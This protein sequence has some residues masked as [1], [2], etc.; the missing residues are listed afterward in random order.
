QRGGR[1][2]FGPTGQIGDSSVQDPTATLDALARNTGG[3]LLARTGDVEAGMA[4]IAEEQNSYYVLGYVP[5]KDPDPG[6]CHSLKVKVGRD[7]MNVRA[8]SEY[9]EAK[10]L[11]VLA[12]T[13]TQ[14]DLEARLAGNASSTIDASVQAPFFY[15]GENTAR[16]DLALDV[17]G[18]AVRFVKEKGKFA[19]NL[20]IVGIAFLGDGGVGARFSDNIRL[21][22][23]SKKQVEEFA[24]QPYHYEKQFPIG[25]GDYRLKIAFTA[26]ESFGK[27]EL[28]LSVQPWTPNRFWLSGL[29]L[30]T[31][32]HPASGDTLS[33]GPGLFDDKVPL[34]VNGVQLIPAGTNRLHKA[35]KAY[36]YAE[37]YDPDLSPAEV[38][39][40]VLDVQSGKVVKDLG[41]MQVNPSSATELK[42][43]PLGI[44]LPLS[45][46]APGRY[47]VK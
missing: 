32:A 44:A 24:S 3:F 40:E 22:F 30:S 31:S 23:D 19:G 16:I 6:A 45:D 43:I 35:E 2:G 15:T 9:C 39:G 28:P 8:R 25:A 13:P 4:R 12:G 7:G 36:L 26:G 27:V 38:R 20:N 47:T 21:S 41:S 11:D 37:V 17:S 14:R 46:L 10:P 33:L 42:A 1:G 5:T 18:N 29:A 34:V